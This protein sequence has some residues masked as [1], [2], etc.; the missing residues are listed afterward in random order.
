MAVD[1]YLGGSGS[2][3]AKLVVDLEPEKVLGC[4]EGFAALGRCEASLIPVAERAGNFK[5]VVQD[6]DKEV[7]TCETERCLQCDL[8][9]KI[10][11]V[12]FWGNY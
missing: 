1:R 10:T 5:K 3:E 6:I 7:A 9:L 12:K 11:P 8:R 2:I 4:I